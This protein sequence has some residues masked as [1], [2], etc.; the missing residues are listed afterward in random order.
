MSILQQYVIVDSHQL[1]KERYLCLRHSCRH[2]LQKRVHV[3]RFVWWS[4]SERKI[5]VQFGSTIFLGRYI[6]IKERLAFFFNV[7]AKRRM[8][9]REIAELYQTIN[10]LYVRRNAC[11]TV[12]KGLIVISLEL[13][14][15]N[16]FTLSECLDSMRLSTMFTWDFDYVD[17]KAGWKLSEYF[18]KV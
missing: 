14:C 4:C 2:F 9:Y 6:S 8:E 18:Y 12:R 11:S 1:P 15:K 17:N 7:L 16:P 13:L 10:L 3:E 5:S